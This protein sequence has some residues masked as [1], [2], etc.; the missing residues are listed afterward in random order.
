M[1]QSSSNRHISTATEQKRLRELSLPGQITPKRELLEASN[2]S[3]GHHTRGNVIWSEIF[4]SNRHVFVRR[5]VCE[6]MISARVVPTVKHGGGGVMVWG[7]FAGDPVSDLFRIKLAQINLPATQ[8]Q[9][10]GYAY[11]W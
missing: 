3:N 9:K 4:G 10:L 5:R 7:C 6:Q 1:L 8:A 11:N 2:M